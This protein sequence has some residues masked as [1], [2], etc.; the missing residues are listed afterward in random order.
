MEFNLLDLSSPFIS[1]HNLQI[2]NENQ[3]L[4]MFKKSDPITMEPFFEFHLF[5]LDFQNWKCKL[6][7]QKN[8]PSHGEFVFDGH[9]NFAIIHNRFS[10]NRLMVQLGCIKEDK[11]SFDESIRFI[12]IKKNEKLNRYKVSLGFLFG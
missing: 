4:L 12:S 7:D 2:I 3:C 6:L 1:S 5:Q 9:G 10:N 11:I 8:S